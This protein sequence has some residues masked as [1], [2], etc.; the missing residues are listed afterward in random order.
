M[1]VS[2]RLPEELLLGRCVIYLPQGRYIL[3]LDTFI[4]QWR[5]ENIKSWR[6]EFSIHSKWKSSFSENTHI[7]VWNTMK[8]QDFQKNLKSFYI[9]SG[10]FEQVG[11]PR[12]NAESQVFQKR[13][14]SR[15]IAFR[16]SPD[17]EERPPGGKN[18]QKWNLVGQNWLR[19]GEDGAPALNYIFK[20]FPGHIVRP[21]KSKIPKFRNV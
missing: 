3:F 8:N 17:S 6:N 20:Y 16:R 15:K 13:L 2:K 9:D 4:I 12:N 5:S 18:R 21:K 11:W 10:H 1:A 7:W 19:F 14:F